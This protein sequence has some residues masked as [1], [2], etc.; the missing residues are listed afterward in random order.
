MH[1]F[2]TRM[3]RNIN[4]KQVPPEQVNDCFVG[5][6]RSLGFYSVRNMLLVYNCS[7]SPI[8]LKSTNFHNTKRLSGVT[9]ILHAFITPL[10][11]E[12]K[13]TFAALGI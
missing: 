6:Y 12:G 1:I 5:E 8:G 9:L 4:S 7:L 11:A 10:Q 13:T 2:R 3:H